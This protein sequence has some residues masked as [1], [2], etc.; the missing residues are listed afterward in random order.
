MGAEDSGAGATI[1]AGSKE[2]WQ[3]AMTAQSAGIGA[4]AGLGAA[5]P[6]QEA[7]GSAAPDAARQCAAGD[8]PAASSAVIRARRVI[9]DRIAD[10]ALARKGTNQLT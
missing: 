1:A 4:R 2:A 6:W 9:P 5:P 3:Q 10:A 7:S 8:Q